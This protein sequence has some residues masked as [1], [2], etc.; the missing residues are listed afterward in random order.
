MSRAC[1]AGGFTLIEVMV[2]VF[3]LSVM[4][5]A[6][7]STLVSTQRARARS[8]RWLQATQLA[9]EGIEQ[10]RA[11]QALSAVGIA[12]GFE[13]SGEVT[14]WNGQLGLYRLEVTVSW[15]DGAPQKFQLATLAR[16]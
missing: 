16:R 1:R 15:N 13:R 6:L 14:P 12:A 3:L 7:S 2:A 8:E 9:A 5:L 10:L 11:G 4:S